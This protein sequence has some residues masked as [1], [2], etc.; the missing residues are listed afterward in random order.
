[1]TDAELDTATEE[2]VAVL[3]QLGPDVHAAYRLVRV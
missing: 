3:M 2:I 1:M